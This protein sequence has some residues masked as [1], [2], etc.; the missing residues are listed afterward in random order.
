MSPGGGGVGSEVAGVQTFLQR[1][2]RGSNIIIKLIRKVMRNGL[3]LVRNF[4]LLCCNFLVII[5]KA[6]PGGEWD[7]IFEKLCYKSL[8]L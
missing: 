1:G 4:L 8:T 5:E 2:G 6:F 7:Q 3:L